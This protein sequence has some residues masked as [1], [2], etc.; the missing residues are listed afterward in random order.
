MGGS[1]VGGVRPPPPTPLG[2]AELL[3]K[4]LIT[5]PRLPRV[6]KGLVT[7]SR[8]KACQHDACQLLTP[9]RGPWKASS[10]P[11]RHSLMAA[12]FALSAALTLPPRAAAP[13]MAPRT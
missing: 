6:G 5:V 2:D 7:V 4:A 3:S 13:Q 11:A 9:T 1:G 10:A 8:S 12:V